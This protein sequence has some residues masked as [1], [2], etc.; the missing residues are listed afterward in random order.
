MSP[1]IKICSVKV[2]IYTVY[3]MPLLS[4][5]VRLLSHTVSLSPLVLSWCT[6]VADHEE[7]V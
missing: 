4:L 3:L 5:V 7:V 2:L 6:I 1:E